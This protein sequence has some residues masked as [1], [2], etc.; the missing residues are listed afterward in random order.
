M[1][2]LDSLFESR[3]PDSSEPGAQILIARNGV[4]IY[5][6]Y[7]GMAT[8][9]PDTP[10]DSTSRFCIASIS[11]QFTVVGLL[12]QVA[13]GKLRLT[14]PVSRHLPYS[15]PLWNDI[16]LWHLASHTSGIPDSRDR[17]D[18]NATV[19]ATDSSS[20]AYFN[21]ISAADLKF[22]PGT[23]YDYLNPSFLILARAMEQQTGKMFTESQKELIFDP[24]GMSHT[25]Y[26]DPDATV[27]PGQSHAYIP[28]PDGWMEYDYG[29]E[30]F[31]AT[32]PDGGIYTTARDL[33][34]W[35][36]ALRN[37]VILPENLREEAYRPYIKV[38]GSPWCDYQNY[39]DTYYGLGWYS[40]L[41]PDRPAKIFHTGDNG[42]YQAYLAK[43][44]HT[45]LV[46]I[47]LENRNDRDRRGMT[48]QVE[49]ILY[50]H[51]FTEP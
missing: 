36:E 9:N 37:N 29:E 30:T 40:E 31:F 12:T 43:Y 16:Q 18:R 2:E 14:D 3:Y 4:P 27:T 7:F 51:G 26:F 23:A 46:I 38:S 22:T 42:G 41:K 50:C 10:V 8:L 39:P 21:N 13:D 33:L 48:E 32:R 34:R 47:I 11:K 44:P 5:E 6:R 17:S 49:E 24:A 15:D 25:S 19:Y 45:G 28:G 1:S 35:E 20:M